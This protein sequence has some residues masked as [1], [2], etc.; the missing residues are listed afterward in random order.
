MKKAII[1]I[2]GNNL[3]HNIKQMK[4]KPSNLDFKK[5][6]DFICKHFN[7]NLTPL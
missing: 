7:L 2:D 4:I 5:L 3:Y 6:V 1:F